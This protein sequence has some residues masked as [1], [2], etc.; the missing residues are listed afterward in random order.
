[1]RS[2][3]WVEEMDAPRFIGPRVPSLLFLII[4]LPA[5]ALPTHC[6][7][8]P[9]PYQPSELAR[10]DGLV[11]ILYFVGFMLLIGVLSVLQPTLFVRRC[12]GLGY[13]LNFAHPWSWAVNLY[14]L[15]GIPVLLTF[16]A[17]SRPWALKGSST[18]RNRP[19][20]R[21]EASL[22]IKVWVNKPTGRYYCPDSRLYGHTE[23]GAYMSQ[24]E[25]LQDGYTPALNEPCR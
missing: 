1:M 8:T 4:C 10:K 16:L 2:L 6:Q 3:R 22:N 13:T 9:D 15:V 11:I 14:F 12:S 24:G 19:Q 17:L 7:Q 25:A 18:P 20:K 23:S 21:G 5:L